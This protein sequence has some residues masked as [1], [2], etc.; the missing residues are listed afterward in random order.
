MEHHPH[1][2]S[3]VSSWKERIFVLCGPGIAITVTAAS[4]ALGID[5]EALA[6]LWPAA[7]AWTVFASLACALRRGICHGHWS[8]FGKGDGQD[9][10]REELVDWSTGTGAWLDIAIAEQHEALMR[11]DDPLR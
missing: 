2:R 5:G 8:S 6:L 10:S 4:P 3:C 1:C 11:E 9:R 7:L